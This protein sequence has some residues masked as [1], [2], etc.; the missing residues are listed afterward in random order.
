MSMHL[1]SAKVVDIV[2]TQTV[3]GY[4]DVANFEIYS[5]ALTENALN[6]ITERMVE[7]LK[8]NESR[9]ARQNVSE[10]VLGN[11]G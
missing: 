9:V 10:S 5:T 2:D 8:T 1:A 6:D 11:A 7:D 3:V 4:G